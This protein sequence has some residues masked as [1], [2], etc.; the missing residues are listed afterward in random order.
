MSISY[1]NKE[2]IYYTPLLIIE[3]MFEDIDMDD[4]SSFLD[5]ACGT[6][7]FI[8]KAIEKGIKPE[9][10]YG[11]DTDENAVKITKERIYQKTGYKTNN[12]KNLNFLDYV[13]SSKEKRKFDLIFT[14]PPWGKKI[15]KDERLKYGKFLNAHNS[16]DTTSLFLF[17]SLQVLKNNGFLGF[18]VQEAFFNIANFEDIRK[19]TLNYNI[20][21]ITDYDKAF[22]GLLTK[23]QA[24]ILQKNNRNSPV[25]CQIKNENQFLSKK[26][27]SKT[28]K[29]LK[30]NAKWGLGI[31]TGNNKKYCV[32]IPKEGYIAVYKGSDITPNGLKE[33]SCY[34]PDNFSQYQQ[35]APLEL[36]K[37]KEKLIYRFISSKLIFFYD[38]KQ[39]FILNSANLLIPSNNLHIS[40]KQLADL[41][42]SKPMNWL[43]SKL[44]NTHKILRS[45]LETLPI[46][47]DY[48]KKH[49]TFDEKKY[50]EFLEIKET[51]DGTYR[52]EK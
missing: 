35:V 25:K 2:G 15:K 30:D 34:I 43:F 37:A 29:T 31:V 20:L 19:E 46:H 39:R 21:R 1:K 49:S 12:I 10:V 24:I 33:P 48:F 50:L 47:T 18:L 23:A 3:D 11:F 28:H 52:I 16:L 13:I 22:K 9:N 17:A 40:P 44:F 32:N 51:N 27:F 26:I 7:N 45:D 41:F 42:N 4:N 36:Y 38:N 6:G 5:P 8:I 14:N